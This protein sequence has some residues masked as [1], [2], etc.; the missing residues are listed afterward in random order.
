MKPFLFLMRP[1]YV[2]YETF[3]MYSDTSNYKSADLVQSAIEL[4]KRCKTL[5][6]RVMSVLDND[7][8][9]AQFNTLLKVTKANM[10]CMQLYLSG[11]A[12]DKEVEFDWTTSSAFPV[13]RFK[14]KG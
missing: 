7:V 12:Q 13:I 14:K 9:T 4:L 3:L 8:D 11:H 5:L 6:E 1:R 2:K 10:V